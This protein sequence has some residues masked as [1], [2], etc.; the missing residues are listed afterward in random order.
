MK[1]FKFNEIVG[2]IGGI[3]PEASNY[4]C[5]LLVKLQKDAQKDQDHVPF[6]LVNNPQIPDRTA[7]LLTNGENPLPA[8]I[9]S[10]LVLKSAGATL[11][12]IPCNTAH[13]FNKAIE[14]ATELPVINMTELAAEYIKQ[15]FG[16]NAVVGLLA[17]D[18]TLKSR[19]Y[20]EQFT[21]TAPSISFLVPEENS[22]KKVMEAIYSIKSE[23]VNA[24]NTSLLI[25]VANDLIAKGADIIILGCT[26]IPLALN[27]KNCQFPIVDPMELL[28]LKTI[29]KTLASA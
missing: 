21:Q 7:Y 23:S 26:E 11:L 24:H 27:S 16:E 20:Q 17:T 22:Q 15:N 25:E 18:G 4:F 19:V 5:S 28:A 9:D 2:I 12:A 13:A 6:L 10:A 29:E 14:E 1:P 3:G 8:L